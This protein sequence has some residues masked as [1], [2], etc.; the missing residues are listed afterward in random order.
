MGRITR[1]YKA[2]VK[3]HGTVGDPQTVHGEI[4]V[5]DSVPAHLADRY[6]CDGVRAREGRGNKIV[7][8]VEIDGKEVPWHC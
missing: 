4:Q 1:K 2:E 5:P 8:K 7:T 6:A 3:S